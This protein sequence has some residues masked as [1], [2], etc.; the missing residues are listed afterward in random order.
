MGGTSLLLCRPLSPDTVL[1][2]LRLTTR[3]EH[4]RIEAMLRLDEPMTLERYAAVIA[5]FD[6]FARAWE[7]RVQ[8]ALPERLQ[9]WFRARWRGGLASADLEWLRDVAGIVPA[10]AD[11]AA[12]AR[13]RL[14]D[15]PEL[16]GSIYVIEGS[17]LGGQVIVPH[18]KATLG[19]GAGHGASWFHGFG[20]EAAT[21][22][23]DFRVLVA[24]EIG[25]SS[26]ATVRACKSAKRTFG[27]LIEI[28]APLAA[29]TLPDI[30]A[31][32]P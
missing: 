23:R 17:A 31:E 13:L 3:P 24:L 14:A 7:P 4:E 29:L 6:A 19:L 30:G 2:E 26:K 20:G 8:A 12:V 21:M 28:F 10:P 25:E 18:L 1:N 11:P 9:H 27:A 5:G 16:L 32:V 22:W 15:L